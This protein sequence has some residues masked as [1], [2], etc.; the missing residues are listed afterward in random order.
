MQYILKRKNELNVSDWKGG[1]TTEL[2]IYPQNAVYRDRNF[3]IRISSATIEET[4]SVFTL[5][6]DYHR[7]LMPLSAALKLV[8]DKQSERILQPFE[9]V[10]FEGASQTVS[11]GLCT[12]IGIML[13]SAW[14]GELSVPT[15]GV[16]KCAA[17]FTGIYALCDNV[18][19]TANN[20]KHILQKGDFILFDAESAEEINLAASPDKNAA[21]IAKITKK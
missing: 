18:G 15:G 9:V 11:Y 12:D 1:S 5:L 20:E 19:I 3:Q 7:V 14:Q 6:P 10:G 21:V 13:S 17:G 4:P 2:F 16:I 8:F